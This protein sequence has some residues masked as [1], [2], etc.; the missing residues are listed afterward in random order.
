M[1]PDLIQR[2]KFVD[3]PLKTGLDSILK[4]DYMGSAEFE[5]GALFDSL[6]KHIRP[7]AKTYVYGNIHFFRP[8]ELSVTY[9]C[10]LELQPEMEM[11]Q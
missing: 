1:T 7:N 8:K 4:Y 9:F 5:F 3:N 10:P 11:D 2:A 6:T